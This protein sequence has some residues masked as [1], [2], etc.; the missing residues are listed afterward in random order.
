MKEFLKNQWF[1]II[2]FIIG[3][4]LSLYTYTDGKIERELVFISDP[5]KTLIVDGGKST[6]EKFSIIDQNGDNI[7]GSIVAVKFNFWNEGRQSIKNSEILEPLQIKIKG[8]S[9]KILDQTIVASTRPNIVNASV[10]K[11]TDDTIEIYFKI[12][13]KEDGFSG[14]IIYN[15]DKNAEIEFVGELEGVSKDKIIRENK[16]E[17]RMFWRWYFPVV[18][19]F[20][21]TIIIGVAAM[22]IFTK[23]TNFVDSK[24]RISH[25]PNFQKF[26]K[27]FGIVLA[28]AFFLG[29][30]GILTNAT[31]KGKSQQEMPTPL[32]EA[33][34]KAAQSPKPPHIL[35]ME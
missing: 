30:A 21:A 16:L 33:I 18:G 15:G 4:L 10:T 20:F 2:T 5:I 28:G 6:T 25:K 29:Y 7:K 24:F 13:E 32:K 1:G 31:V 17:Q 22:F 9:I 11:R 8:D 12:L 3:C 23:I 34:A 19:I 14:Q 26:S 35:K 27:Y